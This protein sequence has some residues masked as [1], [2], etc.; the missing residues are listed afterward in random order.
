M[1]SRDNQSSGSNIPPAPR[2]PQRNPLLSLA[3]GSFTLEDI[4]PV[5]LVPVTPATPAVLQDGKSKM[6]TRI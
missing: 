5:R 3:E 4:T 2:L 6:Y 1:H